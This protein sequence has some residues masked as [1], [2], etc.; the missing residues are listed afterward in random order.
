MN[1]SL[2][3]YSTRDYITLRQQLLAIPELSELPE[4]VIN[5]V[6]APFD[7]LNNTINVVANSLLKNQAFSRPE[8]QDLLTLIDY[9]LNWKKTSST[10]LDISINPAA[11]V[12]SSYTITKDQLIFRAKNSSNPLTFESRT[13][14]TIPIGFS[15]T[16]LE[17][18]QQETQQE[19]IVGTTDGT[20][21]QIIELGFID[22]LAETIKIEIDGIQYTRVYT[23]VKSKSTDYHYKL[24][25][26]SD[27]TSYIKLGGIT[28]DAVQ[29]GFIPVSGLS[30]YLNCAT[31]GGIISIVK[32]NAIVEYIGSDINLLTC[33]NPSQTQGGQDAES[34]SSAIANSELT[35][36]ANEHFINNDSGVG[37]ALRVN[38]V[39]VA[40]I[41]K[42][43]TLTVDVFIIPTGGGFPT[44][45]LKDEVYDILVNSTL[46]E[47]VVINV[48]NPNYYLVANSINVKLLTGYTPTM[49]EKYILLAIAL[50]E[51]EIGQ[52]IHDTYLSSGFEN[53]VSLLNNVFSSIIP[54]T[55]NTIE[56]KAQIIKLLENLPFQTFGQRFQPQDLITAV[57]GYVT[58]VDY[59]EITNPASPLNILS[60]YIT[61]PISISV[62][63]L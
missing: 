57:Q 43:G 48:K 29:K 23:L 59:V 47:N 5:M 7:V 45:T 51:S 9:Q 31:G 21:W 62:N 63:Y 11:T 30:V 61:K 49:V 55:F 41:V 6:C 27:G 15:T 52:Y 24:Y 60:G 3:S 13:D 26:R 16:T 2:I 14:L 33:N 1:Q 46:L 28:N 12:S 22:I 10:I 19:T 40:Q 17:V 58:G 50:R 25:F 36:R 42:T 56:D 18:F 53:T 39:A 20:N 38:G 8:L 54:Y 37:L 44:P 32:P 35:V 34:I 4:H